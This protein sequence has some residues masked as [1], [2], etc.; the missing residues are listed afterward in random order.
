MKIP[1]L[2]TKTP[3]YRRFSYTPRHFDP[4][5]EERKQRQERIQ[6][7]LNAEQSKSAE[8]GDY[9]YRDR[10]MGSFRNAKKTTTV[11][12]DPSAN[13]LRLIVLLF[14]VVWLYAVLEFGKVALYG[15]L[16]LFPFYFYLKFRKRDAANR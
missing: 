6:K 2:F 13:T 4:Q 9:S 3:N 8:S 15:V 14:I 12:K 16:L 11:Q 5:E 10:I 1:S 7:E